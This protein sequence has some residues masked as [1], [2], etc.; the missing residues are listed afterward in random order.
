MPSV[1]EAP[2]SDRL[3]SLRTIEQIIDYAI[4]EG[5]ELRLPLLVYLLRMARLELDRIIA[6]EEEAV[7]PGGGSVN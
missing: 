4:V 6:D 5:A 2:I 3:A 7:P 1:A